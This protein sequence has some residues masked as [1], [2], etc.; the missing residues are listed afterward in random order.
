MKVLIVDD[1]PSMRSILRGMFEQIGFPEVE[2]AEDAELAWHWIQSRAGVKDAAYGLVVSDWNM[3]GM[4]GIDLLRTI[5]NSPQTRDLP[6]FMITARGNEVHIEE[7]LRNGVNDYLVKPFSL[8][9]LVVKMRKLYPV[10]AL[11]ESLRETTPE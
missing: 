4:S 1:V 7:A 11:P 3:P 10:G 2:E 8:A 6:F 9:D 5:R